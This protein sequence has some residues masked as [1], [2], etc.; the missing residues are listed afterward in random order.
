MDRLETLS[1]PR[2]PNRAVSLHA[3]ILGESVRIGRLPMVRSR[4]EHGTKP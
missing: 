3:P 1:Q 2:D 4:A